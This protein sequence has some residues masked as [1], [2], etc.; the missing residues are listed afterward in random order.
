VNARPA[1]LSLDGDGWRFQ[2]IPAA[3]LVCLLRREERRVGVTWRGVPPAERRL[4][5][6]GRNTGELSVG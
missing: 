3:D 4:R 2:A 6:R 1:E 5:V